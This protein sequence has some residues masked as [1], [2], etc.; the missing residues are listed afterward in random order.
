MLCGHKAKLS[1]LIRAVPVETEPL[2]VFVCTHYPT[3]NRFALLLEM[4]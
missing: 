2:Y 3:Q 4:L 1:E